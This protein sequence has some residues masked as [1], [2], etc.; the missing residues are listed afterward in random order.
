MPD[1]Q[2]A[3]ENVGRRVAELREAKG[4]TQEAFAEIVGMQVQNVRMIESGRPAGARE[5]TR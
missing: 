1:A 2:K 4:L 3:I 5:A